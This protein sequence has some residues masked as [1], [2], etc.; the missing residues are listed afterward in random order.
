MSVVAPEKPTR[1][2]S[3]NSAPASDPVPSSRFLSLTRLPGLKAKVK[4][5]RS[6]IYSLMGQGLFPKPI[7]IGRSIA[8]VDSEIDDWIKS[9]M[10]ARGG[11]Q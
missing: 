7:T 8:W 3:K 6:A 11:A 1:K 10:A 9:R 2:T 5:S 4:L